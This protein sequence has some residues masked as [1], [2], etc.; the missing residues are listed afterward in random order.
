MKN[1]N[2]KS[3]KI[4]KETIFDKI[5]RFINQ[6]LKK[7]NNNIEIQPQQLS[8]NLPKEEFIQKLNNTEE[9][10][11]LIRK[12]ETEEIKIEEQKDEELEQINANLTRYLEKITQ[13]IENHKTEEKIV[14]NQI[15]NYKEQMAKYKER[16][17][18]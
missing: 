9:T 3:L 13:E 11:D 2:E 15:K 14:E 10:A 7:N 17:A 6:I 16:M 4:V 18:N 5:K 1:S 12:I 8:Y